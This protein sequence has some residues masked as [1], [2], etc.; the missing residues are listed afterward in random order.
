[1]KKNILDYKRYSQK[2]PQQLLRRMKQ[3]ILEE[4]LKVICEGEGIT[5]EEVQEL[6]KEEFILVM[7]RNM[8]QIR[9]ASGD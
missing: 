6:A 2:C 7:H 3:F 9:A 4:Q 1:M 5:W 8:R